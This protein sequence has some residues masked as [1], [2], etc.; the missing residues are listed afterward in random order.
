MTKNQKLLLIAGVGVLGLY[1]F[2]RYRQGQPIFSG[3]PLLGG[4]GTMGSGTG[5]PAATGS[6]TTNLPQVPTQTMSEQQRI[7]L[8]NQATGPLSRSQCL[9][10][11]DG[12]RW[13]DT[14]T[15]PYYGLCVSQAQFTR[16]LNSGYNS[17]S[18]PTLEYVKRFLGI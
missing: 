18:Q 10:N 1:A 4:Q 14:Q 5:N 17:D 15:A 13:I 2:Y 8:R 7:M 12:R 16:W 11:V 9:I 3:F 6:G